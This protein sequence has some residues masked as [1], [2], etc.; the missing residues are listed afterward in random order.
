[1]QVERLTYPLFKML[2]RTRNLIRFK[3]LKEKNIQNYDCFKTRIGRN[4][5]KTF[6]LFIKLIYE[7]SQKLTLFIS[8]RSPV[9][10]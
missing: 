4:E 5:I 1:M 10:M 6:H 9:S 2:E 7:C 8:N 3:N